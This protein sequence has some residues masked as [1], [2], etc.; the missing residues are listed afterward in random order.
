MES[1]SW[2]LRRTYCNS[3]VLI[4]YYFI[5]SFSLIYIFGIA[6]CIHKFLFC[7]WVNIQTIKEKEL[8]IGSQRQ[9]LFRQAFCFCF[10]KG[11]LVTC[12]ESQSFMLRDFTFGL[13]SYYFLLS[14]SQKYKINEI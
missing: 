2:V 5:C 10:W 12:R 13:A 6:G 1:T 4:S 9:V 14:L 3:K 7:L 8:L 11:I